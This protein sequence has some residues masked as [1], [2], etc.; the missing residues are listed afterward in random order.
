MHNSCFCRNEAAASKDPNKPKEAT[1]L[2]KMG[3]KSL[4][5]PVTTSQPAGLAPPGIGWQPDITE[6]PWPP[7]ESS[8]PPLDLPIGPPLGPPLGQPLGQPAVPL[9][10]TPL[11]PPPLGPPPELGWRPEVI[12][13]PEISEPPW[14]PEPSEYPLGP[15]PDYQA[16][17]AADGQFGVNLSYPVPP[18]PLTPVSPVVM[19]PPDPIPAKDS[20]SGPTLSNAPSDPSDRG[21][22]SLPTSPIKSPKDPVDTNMSGSGTIEDLKSGPKSHNSDNNLPSGLKTRHHK[23]NV[24]VEVPDDNT[25]EKE[26]VL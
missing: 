18:P 12:G 20:S 24:Y 21:F 6:P 2:K 8:I 1:K 4:L 17:T 16:A 14:P 11:G 7:E 10:V 26:T 13:P 3:T 19:S 23:G 9:G 5:S 25:F 15:A 22:R